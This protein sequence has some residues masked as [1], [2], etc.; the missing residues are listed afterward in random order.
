MSTGWSRDLLL[1]G[2][3][4]VVLVLIGA[5]LPIKELNVRLAVQFVRFLLNKSL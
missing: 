1:K 4:F 5:L 2:S 3:K